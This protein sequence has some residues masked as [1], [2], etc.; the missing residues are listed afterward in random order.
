[1]AREDRTDWVE[2]L[3][4]VLLGIRTAWRVELGASPAELTFGTALHIPG[5][6]VEA[7]EKN[8]V[9]HDFL[10]NLKRQMN[11]LKPVQTSNHATLRQDR[12]P[13]ALNSATHVF[14]RRD[15]KAPPLTRPYT[16]P[17]VVISKSD[18]YFELDLNGRRD[19]VLI[20]RLKPAFIE[21]EREKSQDPAIICYGPS[22][23]KIE[24]ESS[25]NSPSSTTQPLVIKNKRGRPSR[26][27]LEERRRLAGDQ[28]RDR[29]F[30]N[31]KR[32]PDILTRSGRLS[33]PPDRL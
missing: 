24:I 14:V 19:F 31:A 11:E 32:D 30:D 23:K 29:E 12:V 3:P 16:G 15:A 7:S 27:A 28:E 25:K 6:F 8:F 1:M 5:E 9:D 18:K 13:T 21:R 17:F 26:A 2:H 10:R 33:R 4:M 20:D 22:I